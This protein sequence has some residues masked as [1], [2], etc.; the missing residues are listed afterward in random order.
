MKASSQGEVFGVS[1][2]SNTLSPKFK[3]HGIL[4]NGELFFNFF[5]IA[6]V[7]TYVI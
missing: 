2:S 7:I 5:E 3:L 1:S 6:K 4:S